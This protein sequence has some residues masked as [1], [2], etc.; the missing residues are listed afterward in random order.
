MTG[1]TGIYPSITIDFKE[2]LLN[3]WGFNEIF[4]FTTGELFCLAV[5]PGAIFS[6]IAICLNWLNL[7]IGYQTNRNK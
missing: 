2:I 1:D 4:R 3:K 7:A 5:I 6:L